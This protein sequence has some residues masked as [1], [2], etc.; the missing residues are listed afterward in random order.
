MGAQFSRFVIFCRFL[1]F[2]ETLRKQQFYLH[3]SSILENSISNFV[4]S[5]FF[6][7]AKKHVG[8][9]FGPAGLQDPPNHDFGTILEVFWTD[10]ARMF[11]IILEVFFMKNVV[12][13]AWELIFQKFRRI[14]WFLFCWRAFQ[15]QQFY[16]HG[17]SFFENLLAISVTFFQRPKP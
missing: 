9:V 10:F 14:S 12:L 7:N 8:W 17:S 3:G 15:K 1:C 5:Q 13:P 11:G 2:W 16:L 6:E 4:F